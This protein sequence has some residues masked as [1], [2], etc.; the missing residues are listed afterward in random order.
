MTST[1]RSSTLIFVNHNNVERDIQSQKRTAMGPDRSIML[2]EPRIIGFIVMSR[3][4]STSLA[5]APIICH[6]AAPPIVIFY[7]NSFNLVASTLLWLP[8]FLFTTLF[9]VVIFHLKRHTCSGFYDAARYK[10]LDLLKTSPAEANNSK[11]KSALY[12][13]SSLCADNMVKNL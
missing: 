12:H 2:Q 13:M 7:D 11:V 8:W 3:A 10:V 9:V 5:I 6:S 4:D 1:H